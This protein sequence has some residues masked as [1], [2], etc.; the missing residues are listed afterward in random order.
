[1][2]LCESEMK[3]MSILWDHDAIPAKQVSLLAN[4]RYGWN[5]NTTYTILTK[6]VAKGVVL[7]EDPGFLCRAVLSRDEA[8]AE[9]TAVLLDKFYGGSRLSLFSALIESEQLTADEI[10]QLRAMIQ[11]G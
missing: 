6:L 5:K 11:K 2:L 10:A 9:E 1:M 3:V 7:R 4:D 8:K